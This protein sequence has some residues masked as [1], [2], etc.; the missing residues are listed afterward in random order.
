MI[1]L[2]ALTLLYLSLSINASAQ[3]TKPLDKKSLKK[4]LNEMLQTIANHYVYLDGKNIDFECL[5]EHYIHQIEL[6]KNDKEA[7]LIFEYVT[8][9]F[10][11]GH[12]S[13]NRNNSSSYRLYSP[14]YLGQ[15]NGESV[16]KNVWTSQIN[17]LDENIIEA[18]VLEING[19]DF[20]KAIDEFPTYCHDKSD[21]EIREWIANKV[22]C[23][24][25]D[26]KRI[27][28]LLMPD[29]TIRELDLDQ[30]SIKTEKKLS[31]RQ[32]IDNY[33]IIRINDKL[34]D[35]K[36]INE[37]DAH[38]EELWET[39][40]LIIDLRNTISGGNSYVAR[41]IMSRFIEK[42]MAYQIHKFDEKYDKGPKVERSWKEYV[43]PRG[44]T[45]KKPVIILVGRWTGSMGEGLTI[46]MDGMSRAIIIG[47]EMRRLMG[48]VNQVDLIHQDLTYQFPTAKLFHINGAPRES[49]IPKIYINQKNNL[50]DEALE[51]ALEVLKSQTL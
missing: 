47:T 40:G 25:Y 51:K 7:L 22:I 5:R 44:R 28:T 30:I 24:R 42:E 1:K 31:S 45:Y 4:D 6:A 36:L 50:K 26:Q 20:Q 35:N 15:I 34:Y 2:I 13:L 3:T 10:Y 16:I 29:H 17:N 43:S 19:K 9:E 23:G 39:D 33:G 12:I 8:N 18:K 14:L 49:F 21:L 11:D 27:L 38:L 48:E 46:G 37:F 41:G 32:K